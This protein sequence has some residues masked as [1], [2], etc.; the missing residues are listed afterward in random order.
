[1]GYSAK[2]ANNIYFGFDFLPQ[3]LCLDFDCCK[4]KYVVVKVMLFN[5][6][7]TVINSLLCICY[8]KGKLCFI[9]ALYI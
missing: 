4:T 7:V 6:S 9:S 2:N 8:I 1:M 3:V 5:Y